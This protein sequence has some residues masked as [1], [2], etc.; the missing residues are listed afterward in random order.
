RHARAGRAD[1]SDDRAPRRARRDR[2]HDPGVAPQAAR[3]RPPT[4][5]REPRDR[6]HCEA[7]MKGGQTPL[8][9]RGRAAAANSAP[10]GG[11]TAT[12]G[13]GGK[14]RE[15][16]KGGQTPLNARDHADAANSAPQGGST[17]TVAAAA[18]ARETPKGGQTPLNGFV[19]GVGC[20]RGCP[21][22][23]LRALIDAV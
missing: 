19:V 9:S 17:A 22:E 5:R 3:R 15:T 7:P 20:S 12:V 14:G 13:A 1:R 21:E 23:E 11:S 4:R 8:N 18:N 6:H 16:P 10:Q 2:D